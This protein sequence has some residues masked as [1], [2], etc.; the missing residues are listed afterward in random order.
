[1]KSLINK[2]FKSLQSNMKNLFNSSLHITGTLLLVLFLG[3]NVAKAQNAPPFSNKILPDNNTYFF[4]IADRLE[5]YSVGSPSPLVWDAQGYIGK[6][7]NKFWFKIEGEALTVEQE[8][9]MELQGLYSRAITSYFDLQA[10]FRYDLA[11]GG[12]ENISRGF[13]VIGLQGLAPYLF[14]LDGSILVSEDGDL[15]ASLEGE[16]DLFVTQKLIAQPRFVSNIALQE[17]QEWGVGS[18]INDVQLGFRLRYEIKREFAPYVGVSWNRKFG[19]TADFANLEG[20]S[21]SDFG[22][23]A[24][25]R[26]WY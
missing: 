16:L 24:G 10:G 26:L 9:D 25:V 15:S 5:Y 14:E 23:V 3:I 21:A 7:L 4:F 6:D 22:I 1:M 8:G 13:A 17:V 20:G 18:G 11:Y 12:A 2:S 19:A